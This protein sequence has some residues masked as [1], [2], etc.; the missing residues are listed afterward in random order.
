MAT[1][2]YQNPNIKIDALY[3]M[4]QSYLLICA[5]IAYTTKKNGNRN[6]KWY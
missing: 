1:T 6:R 4:L 5:K 3:Q 2:F